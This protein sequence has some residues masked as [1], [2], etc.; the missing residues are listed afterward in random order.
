MSADVDAWLG[1]RFATLPHPFAAP[2]P[3]EPAAPAAPGGRFGP[4]PVQAPV[5]GFDLPGGQ[6]ATDCLT[7]NVW[8]PRGAV[9]APVAVWL[10]GGGFEM[11]TAATPFFD[12]AALAEAAQ[13]VVVTV[14]YRVGAF[15]FGSFAG[16]GGALSAAH[17]L[18]LQDVCAALRWIDAAAAAFGGDALRVTLIGQS[19][20][21][22]L[23]AAAAVAPGVP[24]PRA[25]ACFSG[26]ASR[27]IAADD[28]ARFADAILAELGVTAERLVD[29]DP[30]DI[31]AAQAAVAPRDLGIRN[32]VRPVGFGVA[33]DGG[34]TGA[35][36]PRHPMDAVGA[37]ALRD[38]F[39]LAAAGTDEMEGF[40]PGTVPDLDGP[41]TE[42]V[43]ALTGVPSRRVL[44]AYGGGDVAANWRRLLGDYI[45]RLPAARLVAEQRAAGGGGAY[46]EVGRDGDEP[47]GHGAELLGVFARGDDARSRD[48]Q[49]ILVTLIRDGHLDGGAL[50]AP[51]VAGSVPTASLAP[52]DLVTIWQGVARP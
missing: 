18:G 9:D 33:L 24:R 46:L 2:Q 5:P 11:G 35:V 21:A 4:A 32:G 48:V 38:T 27:V 52:D 13:S 7:L 8:A 29:L 17:D 41:L 1:V 34:M 22:F 25:V 51:L 6:S 36:V 45:Y 49:R 15:G 39:V 14:N 23:A 30:A 44:D 28:A 20:G 31:L 12:G 3:T 47:G 10:F 37:G 50:D 16:H 26:G 43:E 40:G 19:A 42:A